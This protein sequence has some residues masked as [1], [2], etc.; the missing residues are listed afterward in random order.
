MLFL[1]LNLITTHV[2]LKIIDKVSINPIEF[3]KM[4]KANVNK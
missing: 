3:R 2:F 1:P 4:K